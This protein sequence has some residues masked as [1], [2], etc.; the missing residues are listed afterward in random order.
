MIVRGSEI[1]GGKLYV[2]SSQ[3]DAIHLVS[4]GVIK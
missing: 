2:G 3:L 1:K 4:P